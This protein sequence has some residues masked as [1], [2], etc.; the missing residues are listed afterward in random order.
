MVG[1]LR[2]AATSYKRQISYEAAAWNELYNQISK[3]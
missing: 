3:E 2:R 1:A